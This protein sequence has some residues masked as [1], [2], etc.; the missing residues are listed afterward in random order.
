MTNI[1]LIE[2]HKKLEELIF[3]CYE[4]H[5]KIMTDMERETCE[6]YLYEQG[7]YE[8][9]LDEIEAILKHYKIVLDQECSVKIAEAK[10]IMNTK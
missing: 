10:K 9:A 4:K 7:E 5:K 8:L 3:Y 1:N 2:A 6:M